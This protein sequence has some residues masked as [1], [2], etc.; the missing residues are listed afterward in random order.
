VEPPVLNVNTNNNDYGVRD[1]SYFSRTRNYFAS[2][3]FNGDFMDE[4]SDSLKLTK[5]IMADLLP[6]MNIDDY[7][8]PMMSLLE[9]MV[10]SN[11]IKPKEYE[12]YFSKFFI[13]AKQ[14]LKKQAIAEKKKQI[15]KAV[16]KKEDPVSAVLDKDDEKDSGN[17]D[18][19][20]Y[21]KLL[22]PFR[23]TNANVLP[24]INQVLH[25]NDKQVKF[26]TMLILIRNKLPIPDTM[27]KYFAGMDDYRY[28]LYSELKKIKRK[29]LFPSAFNTH[30]D[31]G[32]S[33]LLDEG[34]QYDKPDSIIYMERLP[35]EFKG[36]KGFMYFFKVK[37]KKDDGF[38]KIG[39]VGMVPENA[40]EFEFEKEEGVKGFTLYPPLSA[41]GALGEYGAYSELDFTRI[42]ETKIKDDEP[43]NDQL[44]KI[45]KKLLYS[46]RKSAAEFYST[47]DEDGIGKG[48]KELDYGY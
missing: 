8:K 12:M 46:K 21:T 34:N 22:L 42:T 31:L 10:D 43:L 3:Y 26:N 24:L 29:E 1:Y 17:E 35:M 25:S 44:N 30:I 2:G 9:Q 6:L 7:E 5:T 40:K 18:L 36:K 32:K 15:E 13:E 39:T 16:S 37:P 41:L 38:W 11:L 47:D 27:L 14:E 45:L 19:V 4:L 33:K 20:L 28:Q 23:E 48:G